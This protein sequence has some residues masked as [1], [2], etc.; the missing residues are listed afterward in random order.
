MV[1]AAA[2]E[3][4]LNRPGESGDYF[5]VVCVS[6]DVVTMDEDLQFKDRWDE[7]GHRAL[8]TALDRCR[9]VPVGG[10][11]SVDSTYGYPGRL[12][13]VRS[14]LCQRTTQRT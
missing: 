2:A 6:L 5:A 4:R 12:R 8:G 1:S 9:V 10:R 11:H 7:T 13:P 14:G 3:S